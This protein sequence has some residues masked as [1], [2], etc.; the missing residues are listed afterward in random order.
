MS[1][2]VDIDLRSLIGQ[3][4]N[5]GLRPT[6][7]AF[8]TTAAHEASRSSV[9]YLSVE[10]LFYSSVQRSHKNPMRGL[11]QVSVAEAL[12]HDGQPIEAE[13]PYSEVV[14]DPA[15]WTPPTSKGAMHRATIVFSSSTVGD[16]RGMIESGVPVVLI[17]TLTMAMYSPDEDGIVRSEATDVV[18]ARRH[19]LLGVG[20]GHVEGLGGHILVRNSWG[21][22]WG[23]SGH[24]WVPEPYL[25]AHLQD[26]GVIT[27]RGRIV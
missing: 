12:G 21:A 23:D 16:V 24:G 10:H 5:Q 20:S 17:T 3:V 11:N 8:A 14:P 27:S 18:T 6:C 9:D 2:I 19:A 26:T 22:A 13:W 1:V 25:A 15:T 4:R 7:L